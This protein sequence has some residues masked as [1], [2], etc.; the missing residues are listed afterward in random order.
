[1]KG[2]HFLSVCQ[3]DYRT[4]NCTQKTLDGFVYVPIPTTL[5][6]NTSFCTTNITDFSDA[7]FRSEL[8]FFSYE[9]LSLYVLELLYYM[10]A[11]FPSEHSSIS[12]FCMLFL[13]IFL[14]AR[15][16]LLIF[17]YIKFMIQIGAFL[18]A[19]ITCMSRVTDFYNRESDVIAGAII[20]ATLACVMTLVFGQVLWTYKKK[21]RFYD[22]DMKPENV[23]KTKM[24]AE[25]IAKM[26]KHKASEA[27]N[28]KK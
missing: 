8:F 18:G 7:R 17:R 12:C 21:E 15:L 13:I 3:P 23:L 4:V 19:F 11:S 16:D 28:V 5:A 10:S 27:K 20:G 24:E 25:R 6:S 14:E 26:K 2:P 1:L 22:F 9:F